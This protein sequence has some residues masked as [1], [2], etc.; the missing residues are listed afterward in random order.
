MRFADRHIF[1][2]PKTG[3]QD[4]LQTSHSTVVLETT[5]ESVYNN[6]DKYFDV[7]KS[8]FDTLDINLD[9]FF[10]TKSLSGKT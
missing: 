6:N 5:R 9:H 4:G 10:L 7:S 8:R 3:V 2:M 1:V